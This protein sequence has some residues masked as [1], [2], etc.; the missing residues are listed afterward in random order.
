MSHVF[1]AWN[2]SSNLTHCAKRHSTSTHLPFVLSDCSSAHLPTYE[3]LSVA[4][5]L[6]KTS[7]VLSCHC[8]Q[9]FRH[10]R[11]YRISTAASRVAEK[12]KQ[13]VSEQHLVSVRCRSVLSL[14]RL[15][16]MNG[17]SNQIGHFFFFFFLFLRRPPPKLRICRRVRVVMRCVVVSVTG[18]SLPWRHN[19][20]LNVLVC[21]V[22]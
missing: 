15:V 12:Q 22:L 20:N 2:H 14:T 13:N 5:V 19:R 10:I 11:N 7:F 6:L 3:I 17:N 1:L 16:L 18:G 9:Y 21:H 4:I 8:R